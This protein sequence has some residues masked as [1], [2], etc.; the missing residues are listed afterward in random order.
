[1][2]S[3]LFFTGCLYKQ[4]QTDITIGA[5]DSIDNKFC[6]IQLSQGR[7]I[8]MKSDFCSS[9]KEGDVISVRRD[10]AQAKNKSR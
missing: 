4:I 5:V 7:I 2:I 3:I 8:K 10:N 1:M 6:I 9:L